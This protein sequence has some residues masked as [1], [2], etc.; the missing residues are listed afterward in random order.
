MQ[1]MKLP[2]AALTLS[3]LC[4]TSP[5]LAQSASEP[6]ILDSP[7]V[8]GEAEPAGQSR[9]YSFTAGPGLLTVAMNGTTDFYASGS[10]LIIS[11]ESGRELLN[12]AHNATTSGTT[13]TAAIK[14]GARQRLKMRLTFGVDV[15]VRVKYKITIKGPLALA[16]AK[17]TDLMAAAGARTATASESG[18]SADDS[19]ANLPIED[20]W[21]FVV[22]ISKFQNGAINLNY[23]AKDARDLAAFLVNEAHFAP[24]HVKTLTDE[25]ATKEKVMAELG[26]KWLP[27]LAHPNDLV[28]IFVST[29]GS[30]SAADIEGLNYL[31]MYNTDPNSLYA[32][33][34]PMAD[35]AAA[36]KQRVHSNRVVLIID[37]CHSGAANPDSKG[38]ER[39]GNF[40]ST[41]LAQGTGQLI[42][43]SS[44]PNQVSWES[45][46]YAN[47]VFTRQLIEALRSKPTLTLG[48]AFNKLKDSVQSEVLQDRSELQTAVLKSK[49]RGS[50]LIISTPPTKPRPIP[51]EL[52]SN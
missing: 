40:D 16:N 31:V 10:H 20:K 9:Y 27:R 14:L 4:L 3:L 47:G 32:T 5:A 25:Q 26:D 36:I 6:L 29:H 13:E 48:Q 42:I 22:G 39:K 41:A 15:G 17:A 24:D 18:D 1:P 12:L 11:D 21:A 33:G 28:V 23:P 52:K 38:L 51:D 43:C 8:E 30:P 35:L 34:L 50:D 2:L 7:V 44:M 49:W 37:A 46:R 19:A 45:K